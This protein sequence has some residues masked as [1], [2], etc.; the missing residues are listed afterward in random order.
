[1]VTKE[2]ICLQ[3][4][5]IFQHKMVDLI[6]TMF[7]LNG[8]VN[9]LCFD[10]VQYKKIAFAVGMSEPSNSDIPPSNPFTWFW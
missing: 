1:M 9:S 8:Q 7:S 10:L 2:D 5:F 3:E 6:I 4:D